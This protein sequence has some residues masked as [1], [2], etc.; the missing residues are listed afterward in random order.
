[1]RKAVP[2]ALVALVV[3]LAWSV[4]DARELTRT[5]TRIRADAWVAAHIPR[6]DRIAADPSTLPLR[7]RDV[8]RLEL[9]GPGRRFDPDRNLD[10][11]R[12]RGVRWVIITGAVTDRVRAA[13][14]RY[15][16]EVAFYDDLDAEGDS[17]LRHLS[18]D[19]GAGRALGSGL[20][21]LSRTVH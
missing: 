6:G 9:P 20:P 12:R 18:G 8:V 2:I 16:R 7:G 17:R 4:G 14:R 11:L 13:A 10:A 1:M 21:A 5:D 15:P 3:P 19:P